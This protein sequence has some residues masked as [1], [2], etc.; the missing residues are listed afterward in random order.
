MR[1]LLIGNY[2]AGNLGDEALRDAM[3]TQHRHEWIVLTAHPWSRST[4]PELPRLPL[5]L[6]SLLTTR[7][8][9]TLRAYRHSQAVIFGGGTLF[10]DNESVTACLLW[11]LH[12]AVAVALRRPLLLSYQGIGPFR[13]TIGEWCAKWVVKHAY[14]LSVRE[15]ES[16]TRLK[17]W[18]MNIKFVQTFD[19]VFSLIKGIKLDLCTNKVFI[20]P[21]HGFPWNHT[22]IERVKEEV[23]S[24]GLTLTLLSLAPSDERDRVFCE[25]LARTLALPLHLP[26]SLG[27]AIDLLRGAAAVLSQRYHGLILALALGIPLHGLA[28]STEDKIAC[29]CS[30]LGLPCTVLSREGITPTFQSPTAERVAELQELCDRGKSALEEALSLLGREVLPENATWP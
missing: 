17:S 26:S 20:I 11:W 16:G 21:H 18:N 30:E 28:R 8:W 27:E 6:R 23:K 24:R 14:F 29:L 2:G 10:T 13:S 4:S 25:D 15:K 5:G 19:P 22:G 3:E 12:A 9:R 1:F 7:W